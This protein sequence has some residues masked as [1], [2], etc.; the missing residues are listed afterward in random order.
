[1]DETPKGYP[2]VANFQSS[3]RNFL[4]Y[5]GFLYLH[6]RL[7]SSLQYDIELLEKELQRLDHWDIDCK[8]ERRER[9]LGCRER[10]DRLSRLDRLPD[11]HKAKFKQRTRPQVVAELGEKLM[12]YGEVLLYGH[13]SLWLIE[14]QTKFS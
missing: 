9:C 8:D 7:L 10:D 2:L 3:D 4:Q 11:E 1:M 6:S 12:Q 14:V 13:N 5:R